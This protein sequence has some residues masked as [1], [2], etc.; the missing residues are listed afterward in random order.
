MIQVSEEV[1]EPEP[2]DFCRR[3]A[4]HKLQQLS[5]KANIKEVRENANKWYDATYWKS[6]NGVVYRGDRSDITGQV[7]WTRVAQCYCQPGTPCSTYQ[8]KSDPLVH[9]IPGNNWDEGSINGHSDIPSGIIDQEFSDSQHRPSVVSLPD[10]Q[11][12]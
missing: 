7:F 12:N 2:M 8:L 10:H 9:I 6:E 3:F 1:G 4:S 11:Q 5:P